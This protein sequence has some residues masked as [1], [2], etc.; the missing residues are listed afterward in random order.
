MVGLHPLPL[1]TTVFFVIKSFCC[2]L[3]LSFSSFYNLR[4]EK[5]RTKTNMLF[6]LL[7]VPGV[8][9][10]DQKTALAS[11]DHF[12]M[13]FAKRYGSSEERAHR[14]AIYNANLA[15]I[16]HSNSQNK[17]YTLGVTPFADWSFQE[18]KDVLGLN[19]ALG[20]KNRT[21]RGVWNGVPQLFPPPKSAD[22][23]IHLPQ[24]ID[25]TSENAVT[26]VLIN[27]P[28]GDRSGVWD[29]VWWDWAGGVR[30]ERR[31]CRNDGKRSGSF[32]GCSSR[33]TFA[34]TAGGHHFD[35]S[36]GV[37]ENEKWNFRGSIAGTRRGGG[38]QFPQL[39]KKPIC[40]PGY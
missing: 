22:S 19:V 18:F 29:G 13:L 10:N 24:S 1:T 7:L 23:P 31:K 6:A 5:N 21:A 15:F 16:Q 25:W 4:V 27:P 12:E 38:D 34:E 2:S 28:E 11:F 32:R 14:E 35:R 20:R 17:T 39:K 8:A 3:S 33:L 9:Q 37:P 40:V 26:P 36:V 30:E